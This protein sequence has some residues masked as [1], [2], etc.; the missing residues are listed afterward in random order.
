MFGFRSELRKFWKYG[1]PYFA[2][3]SNSRS[4]LSLSQGKSGVML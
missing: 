4:A 1:K 3:M 2:V